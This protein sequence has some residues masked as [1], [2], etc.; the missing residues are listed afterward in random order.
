MEAVM[1]EHKHNICLF[2]KNVIPL[3]D[4]RLWI[5]QK[6]KVISRT[7]QPVCLLCVFSSEIALEKEIQRFHSFGYS[8]K[9]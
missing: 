7:E 4:L 1:D 8:N 6:D 5:N 2:T 9:D 3:Q